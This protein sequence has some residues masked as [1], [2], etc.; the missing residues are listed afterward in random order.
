M[1]R[2]EKK[3]SFFEKIQPAISVSIGGFF[4]AVVRAAA[5]MYF[6]DLVGL[7]SVNIVGS[8]LIGFFLFLPAVRQNPEIT[9]GGFKLNKPLLIG[10]GFFG[11]YTTFSFFIVYPI[12]N[13]EKTG[14]KFIII[15]AA[16]V[17][18]LTLIGIAAVFAGK[19]TAEK[20]THSQIPPQ[21]FFQEKNQNHDKK[22]RRK[23]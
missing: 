22:Q 14:L 9:I 6:G 1:K 8:F 15:F 4:G 7:L 2:P 17:T 5:F 18:L 16:F 23:I 12:M 20:L 19:R 10:T 11:A 13:I 3:M 21:N